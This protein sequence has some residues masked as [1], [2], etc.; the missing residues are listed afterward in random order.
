MSRKSA[1]NLEP[2][3]IAKGQKHCFTYEVSEDRVRIFAELSGD[4]NP[5]HTN[6]DYARDKG[7]SGRVV[8]GVFQQ[9]LASQAVGMWLI[10][11]RCLISKIL[12]RFEKP[13]VYPASV[14]VRSEVL[15]WSA[16]N[17]S[18]K[19][20]VEVLDIQGISRYSQSIIDVTF[21]GRAA[22][23]NT[24]SGSTPVSKTVEPATSPQTNIE[25]KLIVI[26]GATGGVMQELLPEL[27]KDY[28]LILI[29]RNQEAL[30]SLEKSAPATCSV[31][32]LRIDLLSSHQDISTELDMLRG[33]RS[34][35]GVIHAASAPPKKGRVEDWDFD[36][37]SK[38]L[39]S[40]GYL[41]IALARWLRL[42]SGELG[43]R[44]ILIGSNYAI[45]NSPER[46][47][48]RYGL[49][50]SCMALVGRALA[51]ELASSNITV[52]TVAPDYMAYGMNAGVHPRM[53]RMKEVSNPMGRLCGPQDI[54][55]VLMFLLDNDSGF[56]SGEEIVLKGARL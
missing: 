50:K 24:V 8:H 40:A 15:N 45:H 42:A 16:A 34:V 47:L 19:V 9:A 32:T 43:G 23:G 39:V 14:Q 33:A 26:T 7:F 41:P 3:D 35:W 21:H 36:S 10:G 49:G 38:E 56:V 6:R 29:G 30:A 46:D 48:L 11:E 44:C 27:A 37:Y 12:S 55:S 52:N 25:R 53:L 5:L 54:L 2:H 20:Q 17:A 28:D 13:L 51:L 31:K 22:L 1:R 4:Y 18:G